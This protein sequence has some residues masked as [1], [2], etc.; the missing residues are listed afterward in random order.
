MVV[1]A[2]ALEPNRLVQ[3]PASILPRDYAAGKLPEPLPL[4]PYFARWESG[5]CLPGR[6]A[7]RVS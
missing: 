6:A 7:V 2:Q 3:I 5:E 4:F 1:K